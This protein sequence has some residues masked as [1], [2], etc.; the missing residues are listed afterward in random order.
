[1]SEQWGKAGRL[2]QLTRPQLGLELTAL[3]N[4]NKVWNQ[5]EIITFHGWQM[6]HSFWDGKHMENLT[7]FAL[8][9]SHFPLR[10]LPHNK[11]L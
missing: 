2:L 9:S 11:N 4:Q 10:S 7:F 5:G 3:H 8:E 1:M 6:V